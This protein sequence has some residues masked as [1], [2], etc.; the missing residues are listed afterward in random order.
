MNP[1]TF[2]EQLFAG[3]WKECLTDVNYKETSSWLKQQDPQTEVFV[4]FLFWDSSRGLYPVYVGCM[5]NGGNP[6]IQRL[7]VSK[8]DSPGG[9]NTPDKLAGI[10]MYCIPHHPI[11]NAKY[12]TK[13]DASEFI[14]RVIEDFE[15]K[16]NL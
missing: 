2:I 14:K 3:N 9:L 11:W 1:K 4:K 12:T 5:P 10:S 15:E 6:L 7:I 13:V 8:N 16:T